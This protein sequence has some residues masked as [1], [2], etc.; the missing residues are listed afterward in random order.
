[1]SAVLTQERLKELLSYDSKS[2]LFTNRITRNSRAIKG[3]LVGSHDNLG[4]IQLMIDRK[5][6]LAHRLA[7]LYMTG[8]IPKE[9]DHSNHIRSDNRWCNLA[10]SERVSNARN[11]SLFSTNQSG[12]AGI[13]KNKASNKWHAQITILGKKIHLGLFVEIEDAIQARKKA[14]MENGFHPNHGGEICQ[15]RV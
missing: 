1:M 8:S 15:Q 11:Q 13:Y 10:A 3:C 14:E 6:Y 2:G 9:V 4:Y 7:F 5:G 12:Y